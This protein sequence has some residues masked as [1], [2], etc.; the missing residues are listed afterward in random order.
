MSSRKFLLLLRRSGVIFTLCRRFL[1]FMVWMSR[2][3]LAFNVPVSRFSLVGPRWSWRRRLFL[4]S[5][6]IVWRT[7]LIGMVLLL[8]RANGRRILRGALAQMIMKDRR[9]RNGRL[10]LL[11]LLRCRRR[12]VLRRVILLVLMTLS[13]NPLIKGGAHTECPHLKDANFNISSF[14][15][16]VPAGDGAHS[17]TAWE[18]SSREVNCLA[19]DS[20]CSVAKEAW[21]EV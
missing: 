7:P 17:S 9:T 8:R 19:N 5:R 16:S 10:S 6:L 12:W 2:L 15:V 21:V 3:N 1:L 4:R 20:Y 13:L 11:V 18:C 14:S